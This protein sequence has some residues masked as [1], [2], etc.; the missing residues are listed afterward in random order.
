M[1]YIYILSLKNKQYYIGFTS[2][3][4]TRVKRHF[5]SASPTTTRIKPERLIFYAAFLK[6]AKALKFEKYLKTSSGFAFRNKRLV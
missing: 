3:L 1:Y 6:K 5:Q 4:K 2:N